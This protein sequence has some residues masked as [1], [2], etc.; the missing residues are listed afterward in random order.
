MLLVELGN[1]RVTRQINAVLRMV[2]QQHAGI[3]GELQ[4]MFEAAD[5]ESSGCLTS[6]DIK[7]AYRQSRW[8]L[9]VTDMGTVACDADESG[10]DPETL[11][12]DVMKAMDLDN[13]GFISYAD[14]MVFCVG[15]RRE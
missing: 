7:E 9:R 11:S 5:N 1:S 12:R 3:L 2:L 8:S 10:K 14:F 15:R 4:Q 13:D 6:E